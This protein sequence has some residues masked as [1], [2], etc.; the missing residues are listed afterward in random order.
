M[1]IIDGSQIC[2][3][4]DTLKSLTEFYD[5]SLYMN[6]KHRKCKECMITKKSKLIS[7]ICP[8]CKISFETTRPDKICCSRLCAQKQCYVYNRKTEIHYTVCLTC[9]ISFETDK[10][11]KTYC[12]KKCLL[13]SDKLCR[14]CGKLIKQKNNLCSECKIKLSELARIEKEKFCLTCGK[15]FSSNNKSRKYCSIDCYPS[16][17]K[18][19]VVCKTISRYKYCSDKCRKLKND[20]DIKDILKLEESEVKNEFK[21]KFLVDNYDNLKYQC[22]CK[23]C[24][25]E[26]NIRPS[27]F[28]HII[29]RCFGGSND[30]F[31]RIPLCDACHDYVEIKTS[32]WIESG[33]YCV[34][35]VLR[36]LIINDGFE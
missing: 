2:S 11:G 29:P 4:C 1:E 20:M 35:D 14:I 24:N 31:N 5:C 26:I 16:R 6:G 21:E 22:K 18:Y 13:L 10:F 7:K 25:R 15:I 3:T 12:S 8:R 27:R 34:I 30:S 19:C 32:E 9:G 33:K 23:R 36:S 17:I 28:H